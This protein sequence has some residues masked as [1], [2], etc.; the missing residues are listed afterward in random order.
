MDFD[1]RRGLSSWWL[2][3]AA[4]LCACAVP[5]AETPS[6]PF[7]AASTQTLAVA[8]CRARALA[9]EQA[10]DKPAALTAWERVIDRCRATEE[11]RT[12]ARARIRALRPQAPR[13]TN[14]ALAR[15]WKVLVVIFRRLDFAWTDGRQQRVEV[16]KLV[17]PANEQTIRGSV[18]AFGEHVFELSSGMLRV[19]A[20]I[21]VVE[22]PLTNLHAAAAHGPFSAAPHSVFRAVD[23]LQQ[24]KPYDT[25]IAYVKFDA[26]EGPEVPAPFTAATYGS[27]REFKG[28][29]FIT[30]PWHTNYP[31]PGEANGEMEVHEWLHQVDWVYA[32]VLRYPNEL[33]PSS[34]EGRREGENRPGGDAEYARTA[35]E[36]GWLRFYRHIMEDHITRQM[37][38]EIR[39]RR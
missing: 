18:A 8:D 4:W 31:Y 33:V 29:G 15:P 37:W 21:H 3:A 30:V 17:S 13:N 16:H 14:R 39:S 6:F 9:A 36:R 7:L 35:A 27:V 20:D 32:H 10:G 38:A 1:R 23:P 5:A 22:A 12:E 24:A 34:D 28:A 26:D 2:G 11:Q 25:V 19:D